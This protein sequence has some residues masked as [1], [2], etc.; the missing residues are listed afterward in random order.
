MTDFGLTNG[1]QMHDGLNQEEESM[2]G[3]RL[4]SYFISKT[5]HAEFRAEHSS[6]FAVGVFVN[7]TIWIDS[8]QV[9]TQHILNVAIN[10]PFLFISGSPIFIAKKGESHHYLGIFLFTEGFSK[11]S[12]AK[13]HS[14]VRFFTNLVLKKAISNK[15]FSYLVS[16]VF[17][18]IVYYRTQFSFV[19]LSVCNKWDT[20]IR[21]GLKSKSGL[22]LDF[23]N[24]VFHYP[25]LYG[26]KT[27]KQIQA[28]SKLALVV[29][30]VNSVGILDHLFSHRAHNLQVLMILW[31]VLF[32]F[33]MGSSCQVFLVNHVSLVVSC[34]YDAMLF[35]HN[36]SIFDWHIFKWWKKLDPHGL[37]PCWFDLAVDF[38]RCS[39]LFSSF[40]H[41]VDNLGLL[42]ILKSSQFDT[43]HNNLLGVE[44]N[45]LSVYT[46]G[47]VAGLGTTGMKAGAAAFFENVGIGLG[48][49][50]SGLV[51]STLVELQVIAL[52]LKCV[53]PF[54]SVD[55]FSNSQAA[56]DACKSELV[57]V[58][59]EFRNCYWIECH[60][61]KN[62]IRT[63]N[64]NVVWCK[65]KDHSGVLGNN[66]AD[67]LA[68]SA[69]SSGCFLSPHLKEHFIL[70]D[71]C[72]VFG[73]AKHFA[74]DIFQSIHCTCWKVG[75]GS[76]VV[77]SDLHMAA[78]FTSKCTA[79][80]CLYFM[81]ALHHQLLVAVCKCLYNK[82]YPSVVCLFCGDV[83][84]S[85]HVFTCIFDMAVH[86][87]LLDFHAA[88][89]KSLSG[90]AWSSS[91]V[92]QLMLPGASNG[93]VFTA[94][95]KGVVF[96][97][98]FLKAVSIFGDSKIAGHLVVDFVQD[99]CLAFRD[100]I[101]LVHVKHRTLMKKNEL[102]PKDGSM[103]VSVFELSTTFFAGVVK[104]LGISEAF[105][106]SS[107]LCKTCLFFSGIGNLTSVHID[108]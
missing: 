60:Y 6:F 101:W 13:A 34:H 57:L 52:A 37:I 79:D 100:K 82:C 69:S 107:G 4:N 31:P 96:N 77:H 26:L 65:I 49:E 86:A 85:D 2:Y 90:L 89:W 17:H 48:I 64:L 3:Y 67:V 84:I 28:E 24:D 72:M 22:P 61:I 55:L 27:F 44:A 102:I 62:I 70:A 41:V 103:S 45:S 19:P 35:C 74:R 42:N 20:L 14:N 93:A 58:H 83:K 56:L 88:I 106:V 33:R 30:F 80:A 40:S 15:Q 46:D 11:P 98:W 10:T 21:K 68:N 25:S 53:S 32:I 75:S 16:S 23:P 91:C 29:S 66:V 39:A 78:G 87:H 1:Y 51:S 71:S 59:P 54:S 8:S 76:R 95:C 43:V 36:G 12:L 92:M 73:N 18:P 38:F 47:S 97:G 94:L 9:A 7:D 105:G 63:K 99:F 50:V 104:L 108:I 5:G 81:K